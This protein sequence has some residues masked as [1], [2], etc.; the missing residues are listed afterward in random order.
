MKQSVVHIALLV[1]DYD[2][3]IIFYTE[4]FSTGQKL[5]FETA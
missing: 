2:E 5:T 3:A 4:K 1:D